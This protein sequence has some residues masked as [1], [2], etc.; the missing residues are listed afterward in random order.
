[1][2]RARWRLSPPHALA[3]SAAAAATFGTTLRSRDHVAAPNGG[4]YE[5]GL[6]TPRAHK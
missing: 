2:L 6:L 3:H 5:P 4:A 1:M